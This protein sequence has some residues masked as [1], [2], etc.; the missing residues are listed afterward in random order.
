[1]LGFRFS[2]GRVVATPGALALL[3]SAGASAEGL[4]LRHLRLE[5]GQ[6]DLHDQQANQSALTS[7]ARIFSA[8]DVGGELLWIITEA[9]GDDGRRASTCFLLPSE[10]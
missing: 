3:R 1:M 6:L 9:K 2:P 5:P 10:Y 4:L 8:F 7:G